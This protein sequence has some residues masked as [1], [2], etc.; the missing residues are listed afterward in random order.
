MP[1]KKRTVGMT[2]RLTVDEHTRYH[3]A[4]AEMGF[5][6]FTD[7]CREGIEQLIGNT[8]FFQ[9]HKAQ[10][11]EIERTEERLRE[12]LSENDVFNARFDYAKE[13][14]VREKQSLA[15]DITRLNSNLQYAH[16]SHMQVQQNL[17]DKCADLEKLVKAEH[18]KWERANASA[19]EGWRIANMPL[20]K[21]WWYR[22]RSS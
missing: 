4:M 1:K 14:H 16:T 2:L 11:A 18:E 21:L 7:I 13:C 20:L 12:V 15:D 22:F 9:H 10:V 3:D 17:A 6:H 8:E 5:K 19:N